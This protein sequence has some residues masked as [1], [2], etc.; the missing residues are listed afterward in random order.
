MNDGPQRF[1]KLADTLLEAFVLRET[2]VK[3]LCVNLARD[4]K[5]ERTW[6]DGNRKPSDESRIELR[7]VTPY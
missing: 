1:S 5:I 2:N 6:G 7:A 3:D 4:G